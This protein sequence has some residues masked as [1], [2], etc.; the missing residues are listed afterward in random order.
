MMLKKYTTSACVEISA[1]IYY[2]TSW[3]QYKLIPCT[4]IVV[5][6]AGLHLIY[7]TLK[8]LIQHNQ[9]NALRS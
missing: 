3:I 8:P 2:V 1:F 9:T 5:F 6:F 7:V 4:V